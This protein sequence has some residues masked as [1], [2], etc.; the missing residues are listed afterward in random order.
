[1][2]TR[3]QNDAGTTGDIEARI[4]SLIER[5]ARRAE[6][7]RRKRQAV[8][9]IGTTLVVVLMFSLSGVT[10]LASQLD[11]AAIAQIGRHEVQKK[12]PSGRA[13]VQS[14]LVQEAPRIVQN[15]MLS[16]IDMIPEL[17]RMVVSDV[18]NRLD[19]IHKAFEDRLVVQ[20]TDAI[21]ESKKAIDKAFPN[22][23]D[24]EK[25]ER[26]VARVSQDFRESFAHAVHE[27]YP[28]YAH[29]M[30][31]ITAYLDTLTH[32]DPDKLT[33]EQRKHK[34]LIETM[35]VLV[36]RAHHNK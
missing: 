33:D 5:V 34:E 13:A 22:L 29:E 12:L 25:L 31:R 7:V 24:R 23:S 6:T 3:R 18:M 14:Y 16:M 35:L 27:L 11:A 9:G 8:L 20:T 36:K 15:A 21:F 32:T 1:M 2:S 28:S 26:L 10:R 30:S 19:V 17:R 4:E